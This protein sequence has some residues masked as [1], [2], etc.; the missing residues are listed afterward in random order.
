MGLSKEGFDC[1]GLRL[2]GKQCL[3]TLSRTIPLLFRISNALGSPRLPSS[4]PE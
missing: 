1:F 2:M 4:L 3:H